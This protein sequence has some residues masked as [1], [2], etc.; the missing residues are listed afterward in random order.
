MAGQTEHVSRSHRTSVLEIIANESSMTQHA[1][2]QSVKLNKIRVGFVM[3]VMQVAGAEVLVT[4]MIERLSAEIDATVF[5][6]D[7]LGE[8]G[9]RLQNNG[10]PVVVL[11]RKPGFD[12]GLIRKLAK[13]VRDRE[14][15]VLHAHQYT[16]FFYAALARAF[17][18]CK[19][20][21]VFTEHGRHYPDIVSWKRRLV[22]KFFLQRYADVSTACCDFSARAVEA[23]EGFNQVVTLRNGVDINLLPPR[24]SQESQSALRQRLGLNPNIKYVACVARFHPVKDHATLLRAWKHVVDQLP[25]VKLLLVGDGPDKQACQE[26]CREWGITDR[27]EFW[28]IRHDIADI[29]RAVDV[30]ALTS[31]SEAASLTLLE[32]MASECPCV[33]TDVGGNGEHLKAEVHGFLAPRGDDVAIA[34]HLCKL[35]QDEHLSTTM[36]AAARQQVV[37]HFTMTKTV[38]AYKAHF[39][40]LTSS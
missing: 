33:V 30:F 13:E 14:I 35:L 20:K 40:Q 15:Q 22:N 29:L 12:R 1:E 18:G 5:C 9:Q 28:G 24:G 7:A 3:H 16:P 36:G 17:G 4:Q 10:V 19:T 32:A 23:N 31:V 39:Q 38:E 2:R 6:L 26:K 11:N 34:K 8:L 27:V 25:N 37:E 21:I